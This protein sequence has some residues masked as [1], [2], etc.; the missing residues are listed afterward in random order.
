MTNIQLIVRR[1]A[2][3]A[4]A[5]MHGV[6]P[7]EHSSRRSIEMKP[8]LKSTKLL[9]NWWAGLLAATLLT[10]AG[11]AAEPGSNEDM[12]DASDEVV[13]QSEALQNGNDSRPA[14][15]AHPDCELCQN[16]CRYFPG[17]FQ[18]LC[19]ASCNERC[20]SSC[21]ACKRDCR[22]N[23][24]CIKNCD[25]S[26]SCRGTCGNGRV[27]GKEKCDDGNR[28]NNDDCNNDCQPHRPVC[29]N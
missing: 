16:V 26:R 17:R 12:A 29:G 24:N 15:G 14:Q 18:Q 3:L 28:N 10:V 6:E 27:E 2:T 7:G 22:G 5:I 8:C 19:L 4:F 21:D 11:C 25:N 9:G 13:G 23:A 1:V 20:V